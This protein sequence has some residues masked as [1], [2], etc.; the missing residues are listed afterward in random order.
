MGREKCNIQGEEEHAIEV[1][2]Y[3][4]LY[5]KSM[6]EYKETDRKK[7]AWREIEEKLCYE[8]GKEC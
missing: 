1:E 2:I 6:K 7:N 4:C 8:E 5:D 3:P